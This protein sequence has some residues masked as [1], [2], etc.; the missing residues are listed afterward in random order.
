[1]KI[2]SAATELRKAETCIPNRGDP[3]KEKLVKHLEDALRELDLSSAEYQ[4][5]AITLTKKSYDKDIES[6]RR[7]IEKI[8][9]DF[10]TILN[11][12]YLAGPGTGA[13]AGVHLQ[14]NIHL[15]V[16]YW[17]PPADREKLAISWHSITKD[18]YHVDLKVPN[19]EG[20]I[21]RWIAYIHQIPK[22]LDPEHLYGNWGR[23]RKLRL[24]ESYGVF[25]RADPA[26]NY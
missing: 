9:L 12:G 18:S 5:Q 15:H 7:G 10:K 14:N 6:Y 1:M 11:H 3:D 2:S 8:K 21:E 17:G 13:I 25:R 23:T 19:S 16:L 20:D 4:I 24:L 26:K 22:G